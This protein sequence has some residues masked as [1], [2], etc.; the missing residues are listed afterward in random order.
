MVRAD[1]AYL[2]TG[3][4]HIHAIEGLVGA[5]NPVVQGHFTAD[6][7][8]R[9]PLRSGGDQA[10]HQVGDTRAGGDH[11]HAHLAGEPAKGLG[12]EDRVLLMAAEHELNR[13]IKQGNEQAVDLRSRDAKHMGNPM[14][15]QHL[16]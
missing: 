9:I 13:R 15:F 1:W 4:H 6:R 2:V 14:V 7:Q 3:V 16:D 8:H 11:T 5:L 10:R 12:H